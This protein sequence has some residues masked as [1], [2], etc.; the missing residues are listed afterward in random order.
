[1]C[2]KLKTWWIKYVVREFKSVHREFKWS[3]REYK[4]EVSEYNNLPHMSKY[5][6]IGNNIEHCP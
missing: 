3:T 6:D 2:K 4:Y 1:M 5:N